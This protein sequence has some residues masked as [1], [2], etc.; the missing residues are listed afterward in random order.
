MLWSA[1]SRTQW[2]FATLSHCSRTLLNGGFCNLSPSG[3]SLC[4][5]S[6]RSQT[7]PPSLY[8]IERFFTSSRR[9]SLGLGPGRPRRPL[10]R[11]VVVLVHH[12]ALL[13]FEWF[14]IG[15][16]SILHCARCSPHSTMALSFRTDSSDIRSRSASA[17]RR[18]RISSWISEA[19]FSRF[20]WVMANARLLPTAP[21]PRSYPLPRTGSSPQFQR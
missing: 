16:R 12:G 18:N 1:S 5:A 9:L 21:T 4:R 3:C 10:A 2:T 8:S 11:P 7:A 6:C 17:G 15:C 20:V 19:R 13:A 14:H